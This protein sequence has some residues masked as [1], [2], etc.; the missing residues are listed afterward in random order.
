[1]K[2]DEACTLVSLYDLDPMAFFLH[3]LETLHFLNDLIKTAM[4]PLRVIAVVRIS[5][6]R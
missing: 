6:V 5:E 2:R 1:M 3:D 4:T